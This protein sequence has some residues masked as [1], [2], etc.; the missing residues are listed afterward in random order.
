MSFTKG[1]GFVHDAGG[2]V[3]ASSIVSALDAGTTPDQAESIR[4][5]LRAEGS[6]N[7]YHRLARWRD[8]LKSATNTNVPVIAFCGDSMI[9]QAVSQLERPIVNKLGVSGFAFAPVTPVGGAVSINDPARWFNSTNQSADPTS[10][11]GARLSGS[12]HSA[13]L[14]TGAADNGAGDVLKLYY[15]SQPGGGVFKVQTKENGGAW[16]DEVG[17][18]SV[19]SDAALAGQVITIT[20]ATFRKTYSI[21][22]VWVSG[23]PVDVVGIGIYIANHLG[24]RFAQL[25]AGGGAGNMV[26]WVTMP[27]SISNPIFK[28]LGIDL[29]IFS[30]LDGDTGVNS[31]QAQWQDLVGRAGA[32]NIVSITSV[33]T[34][35]GVPGGFTVT[36]D[37]P[38][39]FAVGDMAKIKG[40]NVATYNSQWWTISTVPTSTTFFCRTELNPGT[41]TATGSVAREP[42]W[43][44]IGPPIGEDAAQDAFRVLQ[45]NAMEALAATRQD[46][47]WDNRRWAESVS[48]AISNQ[49]ISVGDVHYSLI[50]R[51]NWVTKMYAETGVLENAERWDY[52]EGLPFHKGGILRRYRNVNLG[53][54]APVDGEFAGN[55]RIC[56]PDGTTGNGTLFVEDATTP[57]PTATA[58][59]RRNNGTGL[60]GLTGADLWAYDAGAGTGSFWY[61][62]G[63]TAG[64][65]LGNLGA[66]NVPIR[67]LFLAK[68][69]TAAGTTGAQTINKSSGS[70]NFAAGATSLVVT[71]NLAVAPTS[72]QTGSIII[73]TVRTNDATMKSAAVVCSSNGSFTIHANAAPTGEVRVDFLIIAP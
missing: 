68:T 64:T 71:N 67:A 20:K 49:F 42:T 47:Y 12:G 40:S 17:Y 10:G 61:H 52:S 14:N 11:L 66:N 59:F 1:G 65:P 44:C 7:S 15:I 26:D 39:G 72:G 63:S 45:A 28:D 60:L 43:L 37:A 2:S 55:L 29:V 18:T 50:A 58:Q 54:P 51:K 62:F 13:E 19:N 34:S 25:H 56:N 9:N 35:P 27:A 23:G 16:T 53:L 21:R 69:I 73:A 36:T 8:R 38:H 32:V 57:G 5:D 31:Y 48:A 22:A 24:V 33:P 6:H 70:V 4:I 30:H 46:A 3:T 41:A